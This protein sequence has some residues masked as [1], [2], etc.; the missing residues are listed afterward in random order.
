MRVLYISEVQWLSQISRKH[1][2]VRRFPDDWNVLFLSP[3]NARADENSFRERTDARHPHVRYASLPLPKPDSSI[4]P[5][6]ALTRV[7]SSTGLRAL[8]SRVRS[9]GPDVV[10]CSYI[11]AAPV[12]S[13][14]KELGIPVVYDCND[15][16][17]EFY[18]ACP[19]AAERVFRDL[20]AG[21]TEVVSSSERLREV[22]GRGTIVGNGV[23]LGIFRGRREG[24]LPALIAESPLGDCAQLVAYVGSVDDRI[25]FDVLGVLTEALSDLQARTGVVCIGRVFAGARAKAEALARKHPEH[26]V[27]TGR[28]PYEKLPAYFSHA[29]VG[30]APF[31]LDERTRAINPNK[32]YMYAA[33]EQNIVS[34]PFSA[35][36]REHEDLIFIADDP[37]SFA[38]AVKQALD[39]EERRRAVR[40]RIAVPNSWDEKTRAFLRVLARIASGGR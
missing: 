25:D 37:D 22:C 26:I 38:S 18:P 33:M 17:P 35:D 8:L 11:W 16:H 32:L 4:A 28:V 5:V 13:S 12:V 23:D 31:V 15:L 10:V 20:V 34:T 14:I 9:F 24:P 40:D 30:I 2:M 36:I 1:Q 6:R 19:D 3:V 39:D 21:A 27:F 29:T 7:L